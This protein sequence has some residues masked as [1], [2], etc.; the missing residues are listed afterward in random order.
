MAQEALDAYLTA[1]ASGRV[2][3][4][5]DAVDTLQALEVVTPG[6]GAAS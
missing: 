1:E 3:E 2:G 6:S 5:E 4:E